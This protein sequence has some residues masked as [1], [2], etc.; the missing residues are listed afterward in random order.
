MPSSTLSCSW[1]SCLLCSKNMTWLRCH[2]LKLAAS[3]SPVFCFKRAP[4]KK[5]ELTCRRAR[6]LTTRAED[7][8]AMPVDIFLAPLQKS[9]HNL[10]DNQ[11]V[12]IFLIIK[13]EPVHPKPLVWHHCRLWQTGPAPSSYCWSSS[14]HTLQCPKLPQALVGARCASLLPDSIFHCCSSQTKE[15]H[16]SLLRTKHDIV[17][18]LM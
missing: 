6:M 5:K 7:S 17:S 11:I 18:T 8:H 10:F 12:P 3:M 13:S 14:R 2:G 9:Y 4:E 1:C 16:C 15:W